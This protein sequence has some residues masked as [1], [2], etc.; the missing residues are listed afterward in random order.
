MKKT[1][2]LFLLVTNFCHAQ[3][4]DQTKSLYTDK[5][6]LQEIKKGQELVIALMKEKNIPG[7]SIC[8]ATKNEIIWTQGFGYADLENKIQVTLNS[9]FRVGSISKT[10]TALAL[11]KLLEEKQVEL[12]DTAQKYASYFPGKN[13]PVTIYEIASHTAGIRDYNYKN[14][15]YVSDKH[16]NNVEE[17][18]DIFKDDSLL[19]RPG[20]KFSY[21]TYGYVLLGAC[22]EGAVKQ[23]FPGFMNDS[24]FVPMQ[25]ENT[26]PDYNDSIIPHRVRFYDESNGKIINGYHVD[27]SNKWAGGGFLSTS[28]DLALMSQNLLSHKFL[29]EAT[30]EKLWSA[31]TLLN[32][33][34]VNYGI[35]WRLDVDSLQRKYV[36]HGGSSIG[37]RSFLLIYPEQQLV[38]AITCNLSTNFDQRFVLKLTDL[39]IKDTIR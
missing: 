11:G 12:T 25:L 6:F 16:Y 20:T 24:V 36:Y 5:R 8:V 4:I 13:Y 9:K 29:K 15:E 27:N 19:F 2:V 10:L 18:V 22:I 35:G 31:D 1:A 17:S 34:K 7:L 39:F 26:V 23:S 3:V 28:Y 32:G 33:E 14:H 37:G 30:I 21:S 38:V